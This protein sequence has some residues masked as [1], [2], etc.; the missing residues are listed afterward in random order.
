MSKTTTSSNWGAKRGI[1][2][3][4]QAGFGARA[5]LYYFFNFDNSDEFTFIF[6][7]VGIGLS[8]GA[9]GGDL[10]TAVGRSILGV[11]RLFS[12]WKTI[13]APPVPSGFYQRIS[14]NR[15]FSADD[16]DLSRGTEWAIA[17]R[18]GP[19]GYA[20]SVSASPV[21]VPRPVSGAVVNNDWFT[22]QVFTGL[23]FGGGIAGSFQPY[24]VWM[25]IP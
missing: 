23:D 16:L 2:M 14:A 25:L 18:V 9:G 10:K 3:S 17:L 20:V 22:G 5:T 21:F 8:L 24:G 12:G 15:P 1:D 19:G 7:N 11:K 4:G 6:G 13:S